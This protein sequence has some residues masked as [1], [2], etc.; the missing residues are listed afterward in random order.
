MPNNPDERLDRRYLYPK[1]VFASPQPEKKVSIENLGVF[2]VSLVI[3]LI[4]PPMA[5]DP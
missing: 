2:S 4:T 3:K 1:S 5:S